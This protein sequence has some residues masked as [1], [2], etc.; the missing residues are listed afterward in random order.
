M[1]DILLSI[2]VAC[3]LRGKGAYKSTTQKIEKNLK[4]SAEKMELF[5]ILDSERSDYEFFFFCYL[6][7]TMYK[8]NIF[9][10]E[11]KRSIHIPKDP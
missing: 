10:T 2:H 7:V 1:C 8:E 11:L 6:F 5:H 3:Y 4:W 9:K